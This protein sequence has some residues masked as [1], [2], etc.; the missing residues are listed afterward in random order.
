MSLN[1]LSAR[2][3]ASEMSKGRYADGGGLYLQVGRA[4][5]KS[6]L[7]RYML[8][9]KARQMGLGPVH[10]ISLKDAREAALECRKL[11]LKGID[12]IDERKTERQL[13]RLNTI[14]LI[15]FKECAEQYIQ[16]HKVSW[17]NPK[18]AAQW[19]S[20]L[21]TYAYPIFGDLSVQLIDTDHVMKVLDPIW[22]TKSETASRVRGR[23]EAILDWA[24]AREYRKGENPA[25]WK[26]HISN[27]LPP[28]SRV[29]KTK[30]HSA[31]P[32]EEIGAFME[33]LRKRDSISAKGLEFLILTGSRTGEII[34]ATWSEVDF[35]NKVW[36]AVVLL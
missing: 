12:P 18:H 4:G 24:T 22:H 21:E 17:K 1:K 26:G 8:G 19:A 36:I 11:L 27:L 33:L 3:I 10:T 35:D 6:W 2:K 9:R 20:T 29:Q 14:S 23:V 25:R 16:S 7:F 30:H 28:R 34:G 15:T 13:Q 32:F 31:L 5:T